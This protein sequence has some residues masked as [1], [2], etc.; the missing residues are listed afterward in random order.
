MVLQG[1]PVIW[2]TRHN[3]VKHECVSKFRVFPDGEPLCT[4]HTN[5][6]ERGLW[7]RNRLDRFRGRT[8]ARAMESA[9]AGLSPNIDNGEARNHHFTV[10][11]CKFVGDNEGSTK[12]LPVLQGWMSGTSYSTGRLSQHPKQK[13]NSDL[14]LAG[15]PVSST[16]SSTAKGQHNERVS[17]EA[18]I[19]WRG[20]RGLQN[21]PYPW[22]LLL[23]QVHGF[24]L[25]HTI[26]YIEIS[27][28]GWSRA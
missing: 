24:K 9:G 23:W 7:S 13:S 28:T 8:E 5:K 20:H 4:V 22:N 18:E 6:Y 11:T 12:C 25:R 3:K 19:F 26:L 15:T 21:A 10:S 1:G 2:Q 14:A 16:K 27:Y 17:S